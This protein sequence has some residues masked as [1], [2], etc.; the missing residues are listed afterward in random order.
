MSFQKK[1]KSYHQG[2]GIAGFDHKIILFYC[3]DNKK[4][5]NTA[6]FSEAKGKFE[7]NSRRV[8]LD[9]ETSEI[10]I[11][12]IKKNKYYLTALTTKNY[13]DCLNAALISNDFSIK[14]LTALNTINNLGMVVPQYKHNQQRVMYIGGKELKIAYSNNL[15]NW[16][17]NPHS[18]F[19]PQEEILG[20]SNF[21]IAQIFNLY[22]GILVVCFRYQDYGIK[23]SYTYQF[24]LFDKNKPERKV[25]SREIPIQGKLP[26]KDVRIACPFGL[27]KHN[28][29][30]ISYWNINN[31]DICSLEQ[32]FPKLKKLQPPTPFFHQEKLKRH[33]NN[34]ILEPI[35]ENS[36]ES[37]LVFNPSA[38]YENEKVHL[39][40]RAVGD[41]DLSVLGY[42]SSQDGLAI[43]Y[44]SSEPIYTPSK[45]FETNPCAPLTSYNYTSPWG[46][47]GCEDPRL[48]KID[49]RIYMTY[50]A[51][52]GSNPPG[53]ALTSIAVDD[54][55][56]QNWNWENPV[57]ISLPNEV[58]KNW[59]I[60]PEKINGKY[61]VLHSLTPRILVDYFDNL[62]FDGK[63]YI[64]SRYE[65]TR[66]ENHWDNWVRG[67]GPAPLRTDEG[68]L[69]LYHAIDNR[70]PGRF[71]LGAMVLDYKD[72]TKIKYRLKHSLLEPDKRYENEGFKSGVVYSCGA[73]I[74]DKQLYVYYGGADTIS[75][76]A[77]I[78]LNKL[79]NN[80]K[81]QKQTELK[82]GNILEF[83]NKPELGVSN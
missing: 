11:S 56:N 68:W 66:R 65:P 37:K 9:P 64:N 39:V 48:T 54:F 75:C 43:D 79:L 24:I 27:I 69:I 67:V 13:S 49:D 10:R 3:R 31:Q 18:V 23:E 78:K 28:E 41:N 76:V 55:I 1:N 32:M 47:G 45:R 19:H 50:T 30:L 26:V 51:W 25:W 8:A 12:T 20:R 57:K 63:T 38:V 74:K 35:T 15:K 46:C 62:N 36:W 52:N 61:A 21:K 4:I 59:A 7:K 29:K 58:N 53:V 22:Q 2:L 73:I 16:Q 60:F 71:K 33:R 77:Y 17:I 40:Y 44:R 81:S 70:D 34:P 83:T 6:V 80:L 72:P 82:K 14:E 5:I 42:A